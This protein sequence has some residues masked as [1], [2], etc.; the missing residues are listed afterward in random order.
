MAA[1]G[2][3]RPP[4]G[5][6]GTVDASRPWMTIPKQPRGG[7]GGFFG[8]QAQ[9][10]QRPMFSPMK[11]EDLVKLSA[12]DRE[13]YFA[14]F[15]KYGNPLSGLRLMA[16]PGGGIMG[17]QGGGLMGVGALMGAAQMSLENQRQALNDLLYPRAPGGFL[18]RAVQGQRTP[19][20]PGA[21]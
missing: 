17:A 14:D 12:E 19:N 7:T 10:E 8:G 4:A 13:A 11:T 15:A 20:A 5:D 3:I 2:N 9:A 1:F 6:Q 16:G 21:R 18:P